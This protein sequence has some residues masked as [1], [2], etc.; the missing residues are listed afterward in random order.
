MYYVYI[1]FS[2]KLGKKYIGRTDDLRSRIKEHNRG[3]SSFTNRGIP[4]KLIYYEAFI[5]KKDASKEELFL[6]SGQGRE[7]LKYLLTGSNGE[8]A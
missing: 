2:E 4:W 5:L 6:K 8:V 1:L 3:D 7:R